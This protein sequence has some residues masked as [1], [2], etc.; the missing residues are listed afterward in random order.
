VDGHQVS[1]GDEEQEK[2]KRRALLLVGTVIALWFAW[3]LATSHFGADY[4]PS[5]TFAGCYVSP[6]GDALELNPSGV[7]RSRGSSV[8]TF[9]VLAPVGGKHGPLISVDGVSVGTK[10]ANVV[11]D[12]GRDGYFWP[13]SAEALQIIVPPDSSVRFQKVSATHCR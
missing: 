4:V 6:N 10:G 9:K 7:L 13:V 2:P 11:F 1:A 3:I 12:R 8:G 5:Q